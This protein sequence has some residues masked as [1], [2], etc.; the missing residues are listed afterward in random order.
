[1]KILALLLISISCHADY[2]FF[3]AGHAYGHPVTRL[4]N[5]DILGLYPPFMNRVHGN[6]FGVLTGDIVYKSNDR[7]WSATIKDIDSL[8]VPVFIA[9]GNHDKVGPYFDKMYKSYFSFEYGGDLFII[10]DPNLDKWNISGD[11]LAFLKG[12]I[13]D[14]GN[15]FVFFHQVLWHDRVKTPVNSLS[16]KGDNI[17][18]WSE[19]FPLFRENTYLFAGDTGVQEHQQPMIAKHQGVTLIA[20]GMGGG[21]NDNY[22]EVTVR[23]TVELNTIWL[24][25][26]E[27]VEFKRRWLKRVQHYTQ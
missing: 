1:M 21:V 8:G 4:A 26:T 13:R 22:I 16:G 17:N 25:N 11:Q 15:T 3:V 19:V 18:F 20:S 14:Y 12:V 23:D 9:A 2:S 7:E 24:Q 5:P 10:L 27:I 6:D